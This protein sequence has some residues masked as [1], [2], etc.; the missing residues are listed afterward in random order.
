MQSV[1]ANDQE[2]NEFGTGGGPIP[3]YDSDNDVAVPEGWLAL[4]DEQLQQLE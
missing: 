3:D 1:F 2:M 4:C